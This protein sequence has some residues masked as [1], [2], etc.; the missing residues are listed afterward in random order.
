MSS[1]RSARWPGTRPVD[2]TGGADDADLAHRNT[3]AAG[4]LAD[5]RLDRAVRAL[6]SLLDDCRAQL[7]EEDVDT[8]VVEGNLA[9]AL[10]MGGHED[11]GAMLMSANL[12]RRE[13]VFG[14]EHPQTLTARDAVAATHRLAGRLPEALWLY[15]RVAPQ[16]NRVLGPSHPH[17]LTTRLGLGLTFAA[18]GDTAM[19]LDV[20]TAA[21]QD[22]D[23][24]VV[25]QAE[26][27]RSC[28]AELQGAAVPG[29]RSGSPQRFAR[30]A[31]DVVAGADRGGPP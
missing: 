22:C 24:V 11:E 23:E 31:V 27:L 6:E 21:L 19:A 28:L 10:V 15:S 30:A 26:L 7:G 18:A 9:V 5:G 12:A 17:T 8:L 4:Y 1:R 14:D 20:V 3:V 16:R 2:D 29:Q 25:E 13:R